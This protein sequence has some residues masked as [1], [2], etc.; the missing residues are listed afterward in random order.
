MNQIFG[1]IGDPT[2]SPIFLEKSVVSS[3]LMTG[4]PLTLSE[5]NCLFYEHLGE[6]HS[7]SAY[8]KFSEKLAFLTL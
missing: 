3:T 4:D 6:G 7:F 8:A 1:F 2:L 5:S